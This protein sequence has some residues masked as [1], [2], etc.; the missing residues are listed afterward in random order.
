MARKQSHRYSGVLATPPKRPL[1]LASLKNPANKELAERARIE[2]MRAMAERFAALCLDCG[3]EPNAPNAMAEVAIKLAERHVPGFAME[4]PK[5]RGQPRV[6]PAKVVRDYIVYVE[7]LNRLEDGRSSVRSAAV[8]LAKKDR[9]LNGWRA[10]DTRF[11]R[12]KR[13]LQRDP[14]LREAFWAMNE[15]HHAARIR[16]LLKSDALTVDQRQVAVRVLVALEMTK[17]NEARKALLIKLNDDEP[18]RH[19]FED[20]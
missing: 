1:L 11:R 18:T 20:D 6:R 14:D 15:L 3:V 12:T 19:L 5:K 8:N 17:S 10:V 4:L 16:A 13:E 9:S 7:M 2:G